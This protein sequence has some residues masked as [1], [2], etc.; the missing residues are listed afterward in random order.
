ML[1]CGAHNNNY[2]DYI[3]AE[4]LNAKYI[5]S[6]LGEGVPPDSDP[7]IR[8]NAFDCTTF[9]E[10]ALAGGNPDKLNK[11]RYEN[12]DVNFTK[13]N[14]FIETDWLDN[15]SDIVENVSN[16]Y[17]PV[18]IRTVKID[19]QNWF[20][21]NY[22]IAVDVPVRR[23]QLEYIPYKYANKIKITKPVVIL[24]IADN[25]NLKIGTDLAVRHMGFLLPDGR[26]RHASS[27]AGRVVDVNFMDYVNEMM[28]NKNNLGI[29]LLE[30]KNDR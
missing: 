20:L 17:A 11:I 10:T 22:N 8:Y 16:Q 5:A 9:V 4:Y 1:G 13:R 25:K 23:R 7:T 27:K 24:F 3:G 14:H 29:M 21:K 26:M 30:I 15:N 28:E 12:G 19:K 6:P 18:K 2:N